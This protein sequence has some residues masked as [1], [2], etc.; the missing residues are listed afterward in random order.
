MSRTILSRMALLIALALPVVACGGDN[1]GNAGG[2]TDGAGQTAGRSGGASENAAAAPGAAGAQSITIADAGFQTPES[3]LYDE[4]AGVYLVSNING[5]AVEH[6]DNGFISRVNPDGTVESLRWVDAGAREDVR[7]D[8][9]KG[10]A[11]KGDTLFVA[12]I[13][14]VRAFSR[15]TGDPIGAR[16]VPGAT[17]LN[18]VAV[19]P[20]GTVYVSDS[21]LDSDLSPT[22]TDAIWA[23]EPTGPR[24]VAEGADLKAPNG[25][26]AH[27]D[28]LFFVTFSAPEVGRVLLGANS[29][30]AQVAKVPAGQL[31]G[32]IRLDDGTLLVSSWEARAVF[33]IPAGGG[34]ADTLVSDVQ[35]PAGIGWDGSRRRLLIPLFSEDRIE[36]RALPR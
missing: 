36:I 8:A 25:L 15:A 21:G 10:M 9:P 35:S 1:G 11:L 34:P 24:K 16:P 29:P 19:G 4:Q 2:T 13:D 33:R 26:A 22:G 17:F 28:T 32:I 20:D 18:G 3:V 7:L 27:G 30:P 31:D 23:L 6:D 5:G 12:D 14:T